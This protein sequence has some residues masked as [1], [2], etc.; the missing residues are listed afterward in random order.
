MMEEEAG[1]SKDKKRKKRSGYTRCRIGISDFPLGVGSK[2]YNLM[3]DICAQG[4]KITWPQ[5]F[6]MVPKSRRQCSSMVSTRKSSKSL[7]LIKA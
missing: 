6:R 5:L 4:L 7:G 2:P 1:S 3:E